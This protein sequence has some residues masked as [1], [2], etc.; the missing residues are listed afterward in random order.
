MLMTKLFEVGSFLTN[1]YILNCKET[2]QAVVIDPGFQTAMEAEKALSYIKSNDL[3]PIFVV[4]THGH[5]DH[6]CGNKVFKDLYQV[7]ICVHE[8]DAYM[9]GESGVETA[10]YFGFDHASPSADVLLREDDFIKFGNV[11]LRVIHTPGHT[12]GSIVLLGETEVFTGDTLFAG[13][14]GRTDF[15]KSSE[16]EMNLSLL[17]LMGLSDY[18][19]A[20]PG[21]GPRTTIGEEKRFNP[22]L[23]GL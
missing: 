10:R 11:T 5:P 8:A 20:Y 18:Y 13:S 9:F 6:S 21:H 17:K 16:S 15:P 7:P 14:I 19:V 23:R 2:H 22:F 4:N 1:C 12:P 3:K